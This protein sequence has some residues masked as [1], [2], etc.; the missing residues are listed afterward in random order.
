MAAEEGGRV[1]QRVHLAYSA[2][3]GEQQ[4]L[5]LDATTGDRGADAAPAPARGERGDQP[6]DSFPKMPGLEG[7]SW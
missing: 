4:V 1:V 2:A 6:R 7:S 5:G 3:H